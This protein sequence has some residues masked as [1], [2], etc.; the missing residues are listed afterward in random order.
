MYGAVTHYGALF[1]NASTTRQLCN[2]VEALVPLLSNPATPD[3]QRH[4]ALTPVRFGL[5]PFR[6]PLLRESQC[7]FP[8]L[9]VLR[10]FNSPG[11]LYRCYVFT[12][13]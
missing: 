9:G 3:W 4:Q 11:S 1:Q 13:E 8:F 12:P 10:C 6:S 5:F 2:S 7:C